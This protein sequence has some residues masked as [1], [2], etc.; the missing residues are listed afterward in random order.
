MESEGTCEE[1]HVL[2]GK[3]NGRDQCEGL[4]SSYK[5]VTEQIK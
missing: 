2:L 4:W 3:S 1:E 5:I